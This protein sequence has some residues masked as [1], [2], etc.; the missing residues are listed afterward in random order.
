M[1]CQGYGKAE[2]CLTSGGAAA[3]RQPLVS[4][5]A[6]AYR[7]V[8]YINAVETVSEGEKLNLVHRAQAA[9]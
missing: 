2:P 3:T 8:K 5:K 6:S 7:F 1:V 9:V 4:R